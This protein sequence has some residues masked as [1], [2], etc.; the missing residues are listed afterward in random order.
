MNSDAATGHLDDR[1]LDDCNVG[2]SHV[3]DCDLGLGDLDDRDL[4]DRDLD[5]RDVDDLERRHM[6]DQLRVGEQP[7]RGRVDDSGRA[8]RG[9]RDPRTLTDPLAASRN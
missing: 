3:D 4:D 7:D 5:D 8:G 9:R 2:D 6:D 1:H